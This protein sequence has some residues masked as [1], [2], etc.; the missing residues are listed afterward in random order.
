[1]YYN[2]K[3]MFDHRALGQHAL[4]LRQEEVIVLTNAKNSE[5]KGETT[6]TT[7]KETMRCKNI[8]SNKKQTGQ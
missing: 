6:T 8:C 3:E 4:F 2:D 7:K 5:Q 1:M